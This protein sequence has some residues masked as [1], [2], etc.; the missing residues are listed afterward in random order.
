MFDADRT[1]LPLNRGVGNAVI[2]AQ[3]LKHLN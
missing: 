2:S 1:L 3:P